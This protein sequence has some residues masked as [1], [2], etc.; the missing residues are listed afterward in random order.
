MTKLL[1]PTDEFS[2]YNSLSNI[3]SIPALEIRRYFTSN[4]TVFA[5]LT[6]ADSLNVKHFFEYVAKKKKLTE[7]QFKDYIFDEITVSHLTTRLNDDDILEQPLYNLFNALIKET[8]LSVY[9]K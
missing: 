8:D 4:I 7:V 2:I 5:N 3:L 6:D 9:L 1:N